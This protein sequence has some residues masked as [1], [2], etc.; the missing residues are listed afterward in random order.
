MSSKIHRIARL[1]HGHAGVAA[2]LFLVMLVFS[3]I[4]LNHV[5]ALKLDKQEINF[6]WLIRWYGLQSA[7]PTHGFLLG[8]RYFAWEGD[9]WA[10]GNYALVGNAEH[11]VGAVATGGID[12]VATS[13]MLYLYQAEGQLIDKIGKQSLPDHPILALGSMEDNV[14]LQTP[15]DVYSSS[16]GL[17]WNR[18]KGAGA[19]WAAKELLPDDVKRQ[20]AEMLKPGLSLQRVL[21]DIHSGRIFGRYG[22]LFVDFISLVLLAVA[23][24]GLW[25]YW[26]SMK[27]GRRTKAH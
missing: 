17:S 2:S 5:E 15:N 22:T 11:P 14:L 19:K 26:R 13:T 20:M 21:L 10:M 1:W 9:K 25:I 23:G 27:K 24:S 6:S 18:V 8:E 4:A 16:D 3:G 7:M 12:Y